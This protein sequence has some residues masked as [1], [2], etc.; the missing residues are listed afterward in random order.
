VETYLDEQVTEAMIGEDRGLVVRVYGD[1][2]AIVRRK[3]N[4]VRRMLAKIDGVDN[5]TAEFPEEAPRVEIEPDLEKCKAHGVTPG[6][7]RR[8]ASVLL[9]GI[10]VGNLFEE[11]KVFE[12]VVWGTPEIRDSLSN[13]KD[14]LIETPLG[15]PV[16]LEEVA[17]VRVASGPTVI[18]RES[19]ARYVDV[20]ADVRGRDLAA[21][22]ADVNRGLAKIDFPLEYRAEMLGETAERLAAQN[23]VL[24]FAIAAVIGT[25]LLFQA[26]FGSWRLASLL[27]LMLPLSL[28]GGL[29]AV[30]L[31]GGI[32]SF[33]TVL[34]FVAVLA[35]AARS[36][37]LLV[38][39]YQSLATNST[40]GEIDPQ[41]APFQARYAQDAPLD[42]GQ[43]FGQGISEKL[44]LAGTR[45]R[46][47]PI[48]LT[49]IATAL[50]FAP[51]LFLGNI[52]GLEVVYPM[53]VVVMGGLI[54]ATLVNLYLLPALYLWLKPQPLPDVASNEIAVEHRDPQPVGAI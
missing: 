43:Y 17:N 36:S 26:A 42:E 31:N 49:A 12:V 35:I 38:S 7:V 54:S 15:D 1:D 3:A 50:A 53:A 21:I 2:L 40:A 16:R 23:R 30:Y 46:F 39:R 44:V 27:L 14:L 41:V 52:P 37:V 8:A 13:V 18:E 4:E 34:G 20:I 22:G 29:V 11:Q 24:A 45:E 25:Y 48:L 28:V 51:F 19:V 47:A 32:V 9:S 6:E 5:A 10:E 33:G